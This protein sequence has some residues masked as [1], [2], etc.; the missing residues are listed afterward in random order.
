M[1]KVISYIF[2]TIGALIPTTNSGHIKKRVFL[3]NERYLQASYI[4][5]SAE[6][7]Q[8]VLKLAVHI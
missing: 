8:E 5:H 3:E 7:K 1:G 2:I 6:Y 4:R